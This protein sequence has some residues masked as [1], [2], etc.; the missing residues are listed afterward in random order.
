MS[1]EEE[2]CCSNCGI[3]CDQ[4]LL[5]S[6]DHNLCMNCAANNLVRN[7][8]PGMNKIQYIICDICQQKTEIDTNT[9]KEVLS[10]GLN[11]LNKNNEEIEKNLDNINEYEYNTFQENNQKLNLQNSLMNSNNNNDF[12]SPVNIVYFNT[13]NNNLNNLSSKYDITD[14]KNNINRSNICQDHGEPI[15]YL[16]LDCMSKCICSECVVHGIHRNHEVLNI[17]KAYP[18]IYNKTQEI[19]NHINTKIKEL[20]ITQKNIE[21]K[22]KEI[23]NLNNKCRIDIRQAFDELRSL[24]NKKEKEIMDKTEN[25]LNDI[26][27]NNNLYNLSSKY[28]I[29]DIKYNLQKNNICQTH[30][31]PITYLCLDCMSKCICS[32]CV[33]H[34]IHR[35]HEVLNIKKAYPL[36][37]NK[38]QEIGNH[39]NSRIKELNITQK[40][41]EQKKKEINTL[42]N[43]CRIDIRQAFD[44]LRNL[45]NK[46]EKEILEKA[47]N[48]LNDNIN[49]LDTYNHIIQSKILL[50]NKLNETV[51]VYL[52]R[53]DELNLINFYTENKNKILAQTELNEINNINNLNLQEMSNLKIDIDKNSFDA[54]ISAINTLNFEINSF[55]GIDIGNKYNLGKFTANRNLYGNNS[56]KDENENLKEEINKNKKN[57]KNKSKK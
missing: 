22:K 41:I 27:N 52:M 15:T 35:N 1:K 39:I 38:T 21:Q 40:N 6:C 46:K 16:C 23:G 49:E 28:D 8:L 51:N 55:K 57:L 47:E 3:I 9:S 32:E 43:K 17:K 10:L 2:I 24:L 44:E 56:L 26:N 31:E 14:I 18:L 25:T 4:T 7:E 29:T 5:L 42:N 37:Y 50:L 33:V 36:I 53:K 20:F 34:G 19:G 13:N 12:E 45:L 54:M 11:N 30:G 48:S